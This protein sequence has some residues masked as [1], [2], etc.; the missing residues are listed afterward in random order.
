[1]YSR[2]K[3][4]TS[5]SSYWDKIHQT[6]DYI[7]NA[8][9]LLIGVGSGMSA[10]GG[11]CY[12]DPVLAEKWYPE[13]FKQG[14]KSIFE[15]MSN[16]WVTTINEKNATVYWGF[17][18]Q[19][20]YHIRYESE[21]TLPYQNLFSIVQNKSYYICTTNVDHQ[22]NKAGF[23]G[24]SIFAPQGDYALFQCTIPCTRDVYDNEAI[25]KIMINN[26]VSAIEIR[27]EDIPYCPK[28]GNH[29]MP[30]LR[31]DDRY[32][33][34]PHI[35]NQNVYS[36]FI[37]NAIVRNFVLLELGVGYNTPTIIRY[38][39]E[40]ITLKFPH[41]TLIRINNSDANVHEDNAD[42]SICIQDDIG[43]VLADL[44]GEMNR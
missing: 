2:K 16:H 10:S 29:L 36:N 8:D 20:I 26:M 9:Y 32:V 34:E 38:P 21:A 13:Y 39:F 23:C 35:K 27:Q 5:T 7:N 44:S 15:I 22:L 28:C 31:C 43:K 14:K 37:N 4:K 12:T 42:K 19:H 18:A 25:I 24:N 41:A 1:M 11:L 6:A 33:E 40:A 3:M 17:W 30:N